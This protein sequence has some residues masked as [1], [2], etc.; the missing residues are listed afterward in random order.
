MVVWDINKPYKVEIVPQWNKI[1]KTLSYDI[2]NP[3]LFRY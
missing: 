3:A 2:L 1:V